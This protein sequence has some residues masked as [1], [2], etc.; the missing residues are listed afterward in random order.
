VETLFSKALGQDAAQLAADEK[1][2]LLGRLLARLAHEIRN[3]LSSLDIHFQLLE[4]DMGSL[5]P[6]LKERVT[7][8]FEVIRGE[9]HRLEN[10]VKHF[11]SLAGPSVLNLEQVEISRVLGYVSD[12]LA[13]EAAGRNIRIALL[14]EE[15]LPLIEADSA[16]LKQALVNLVI[17]ALQAIERNGQVELRAKQNADFLLVQVADSGPG[18]PVAKQRTIFE[19]YYTTKE[20]G[21][22]LGLWI[23]EQIA[24]AHHGELLAANAPEGGAV[25]TLQLPRRAHG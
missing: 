4:E 20:E 12:L 8:R 14:V 13:P 6:E 3:P 19:P 10:L 22:G 17:N 15:N 7:G 25:F 18:I 11:L 23:A 5:A 21:N 24:A 16:Q 1:R 2:L 9:L